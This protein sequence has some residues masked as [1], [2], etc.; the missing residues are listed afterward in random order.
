MT[1]MNVGT[2]EVL[3]LLHDKVECGHGFN[4]RTDAGT[5]SW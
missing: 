2:I 1:K 3:T 4:T 5:A